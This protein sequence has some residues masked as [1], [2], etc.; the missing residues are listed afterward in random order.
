[1]LGAGTGLNVE[2][3]GLEM[4]SSDEVV[5]GTGSGLEDCSGLNSWNEDLRELYWNWYSP[6]ALKL[7]PMLVFTSN[8]TWTEQM[9]FLFDGI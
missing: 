3:A 5:E 8:L 2:G 1:M 6:S 4:I 9:I 7:V